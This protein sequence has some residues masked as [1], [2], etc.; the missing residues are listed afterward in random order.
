MTQIKK[1]PT[2]PNWEEINPDIVKLAKTTKWIRDPF[3]LYLRGDLTWME[4]LETMVTIIGKEFKAQQSLLVQTLQEHG[5]SA[6]IMISG[7]SGPLLKALPPAPMKR[8]DEP[9]RVT[10]PSE[11][12][13]QAREPI[14]QG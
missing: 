1:K 5:P 7:A 6:A 3:E 4:A 2:D 11:P 13:P 10:V 8:P 9:V 14:R 12:N